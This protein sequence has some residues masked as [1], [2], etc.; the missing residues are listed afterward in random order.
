MCYTIITKFKI[1]FSKYD[2]QLQMLQSSNLLI[3][4]TKQVC[5]Y[6]KKENYCAQF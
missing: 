4:F 2:C 3:Q 1:D 6:R 5:T